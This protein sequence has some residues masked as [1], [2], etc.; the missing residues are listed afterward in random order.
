MENVK[1]VAQ[2]N[3]RIYLPDDYIL[4][5][6]EGE[7]CFTFCTTIGKNHRRVKI[8]AFAI[9]MHERDFALIDAIRERLNLKNRIYLH[10]LDPF[11]SSEGKGYMRG[12]KAFLLV[13]DFGA[14]K[15][16]VIPFFYN[17]LYGNKGKQFIEWLEKI[18]SD[19]D[20]RSDYK[21]LSR[22][23]QLGYWDR[24]FS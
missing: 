19:L 20:V 5:L 10:R 21:L 17:R 7:G 2:E 1:H 12:R 8:P 11:I 9:S 14:L 15:N 18:G 22:L 24:K 23:Y 16:K 13:R 4:G 3:R 6:V